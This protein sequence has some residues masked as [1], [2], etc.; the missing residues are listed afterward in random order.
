MSAVHALESI[1]NA[2]PDAWVRDM[3]RAFYC[4]EWLES[5]SMHI[6]FL[7]APDFFG[8]ATAME[9]AKEYPEEIRR[10]LRL[11]NLGNALI[12]LFGQRSVH[13]VGACVGGFFQAPSKKDV[14]NIL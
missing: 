6:H 4:G 9:M 1:F 13:P 2:N 5:H 3:R 10:G 12:K 8:F 7:A 11:Q 14:E